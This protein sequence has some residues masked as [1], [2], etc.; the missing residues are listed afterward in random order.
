MKGEKIGKAEVKESQKSMKPEQSKKEMTYLL[1]NG[2]ARD[3]FGQARA[4]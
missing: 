3:K 2:I 4:K 1:Y